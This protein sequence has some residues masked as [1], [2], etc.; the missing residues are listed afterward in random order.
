MSKYVIKKTVIGVNIGGKY[1]EKVKGKSPI[2]DTEEKYASLDS[3]IK[4]AFKAGFL[5]R[6]ESNKEVNYEDVKLIDELTLQLEQAEKRAK[7]ADEKA[8]EA[9]KEAEEAEKADEAADEATKKAAEE[10]AIQKGIQAEKLEKSA[11]Q[12]KIVVDG[13][14]KQLAAAKKK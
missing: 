6:K 14:R 5:S 7:N 10:D 8:T 1:Y 9:E 12:S 11:E 2:F 13:L 4:A 3:E